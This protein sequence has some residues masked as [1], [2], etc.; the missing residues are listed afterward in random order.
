MHNRIKI[1]IKLPHLQEKDQLIGFFRIKTNK[2][3]K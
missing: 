1:V 2:F 3:D